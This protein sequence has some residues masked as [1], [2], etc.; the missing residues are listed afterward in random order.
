MKKSAPSRIIF[1]ASRL[2]FVQ[3]LKI[4]N[5]TNLPTSLFQIFIEGY[6]YGNSKLCNIVA[7]DRFAEILKGTGVTSNS[8]H[9]GWSSTRLFEKSA[10]TTWLHFLTSVLSMTQRQG[11]QTSI[12]LA[13]SN[14]VKNTTG[15]FFANCS[16]TFKPWKVYDKEFCDY[17]WKTSEELVGIKPEEKL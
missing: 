13:V 8:L 15:N 9:P 7:A 3:K 4:G 12:Y 14:T 2:S 17:I 10:S 16:P 11:A 6:L 5:L 1:V